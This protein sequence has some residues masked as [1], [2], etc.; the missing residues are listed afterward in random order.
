MSNYGINNNKPLR[1]INVRVTSDEFAA[2]EEAYN[3]TRVVNK[4][5]LK[6]SFYRNLLQLGFKAY[7][8]QQGQVMKD[9]FPILEDGTDINPLPPVV[10]PEVIAQ[11]DAD[12]ADF[13]AYKEFKKFKAGR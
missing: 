13:L 6:N 5:K 2:Y 8:E 4:A 11:E 7:Q 3:L 10:P 1:G 12:W 9:I